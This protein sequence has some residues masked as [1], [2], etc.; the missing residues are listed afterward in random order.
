MRQFTNKLLDIDF[1]AMSLLTRVP[2]AAHDV[3]LCAVQTTARPNKWGM[4]CA[5]K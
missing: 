1:K 5:M 3:T 2:A 4:K